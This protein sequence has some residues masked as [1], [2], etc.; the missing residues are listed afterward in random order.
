MKLIFETIVPRPLSYVRARFNRD[1]FLALAP[2]WTKIDLE[3]FD[4]CAPGDEVHLALSNLGLKQKWVS[5]ITSDVDS[6]TEWS[7][8][9][10]GTLLPFP[11]SSWRHEH[12]V[13][14]VSESSCMIIDDIEFRCAPA[15]LTPLVKP[16]LW[17]NFCIRP[18]RYLEFFKD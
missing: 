1:L 6:P 3:R 8:V 14:L 18:K 5:R 17:L 4:G 7:F 15:F 9:D 16:F 13:T 12:R 2:P 11:L 10:E